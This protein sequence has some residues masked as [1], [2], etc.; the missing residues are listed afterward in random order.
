MSSNNFAA[1]TQLEQHFLKKR[2]LILQVGARWEFYTLNGESENKP[3]FRGGINYQL[4]K[5][6]TAFRASIGQ[7]YRYPSIGEKFIAIS[8]GRYGFYPNP[9]LISEKSWNA[10]IGEM[11]P[12]R[13]FDFQGMFDIAFFNQRYD[14]YIEFAMGQWGT[15]GP[16]VDRIGFK[17]LN[18]GPARIGGIDFSMMGEGKIAKNVNYTVSISYT[19]SNPISL[20]PDYVYYKDSITKK[21]F[22]FNNS[23]YDTTRKVLKYRI[24]H[25]AKFDLSFSF[26]K[27]FSIGVS[28]SYYSA[29]K[30][31]DNFFFDFDIDNPNLTDSRKGILESL[32]D[33][34]FQG[35]YEYFH[36]KENK[37]GVVFDART[38]YVIK[39]LTLSLIVKNVLNRSYSLRPMYV[40]P[41]RTLTL[42][43]IYD[44]N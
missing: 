19:Y 3:I 7:G 43:L 38:S 34:P 18:I 5:L 39:N 9:G 6:K 12:F 32:G 23:S 14:N 29:M 36:S 20:D 31:V 16:L 8:V 27:K 40:E 26:Y 25:M 24:E 22:T 44:F 35:Y 28:A 37:G 4:N 2:N 15:Q 41:P 21:E 13:L 33:L 10:E 42:Q 30:N 1:Y 17:Y 11:Q